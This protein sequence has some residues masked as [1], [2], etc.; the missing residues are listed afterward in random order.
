MLSLVYLRARESDSWAAVTRGLREEHG[1]YALSRLAAQLQAILPDS[2]RFDR[3]GFG[4]PHQS[5][6]GLADIVDVIDRAIDAQE[7][8]VVFHQLLEQFAVLEGRKGGEFHTPESVARALVEVLSPDLP[9][10]IYDPACGT[11][12]L[13]VAAAARR[14]ASPSPSGC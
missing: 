10:A 5:G 9:R 13:L 6:H 4:M 1:P 3:S 12:G 8:A 2:W 14:R 7:G 11:G